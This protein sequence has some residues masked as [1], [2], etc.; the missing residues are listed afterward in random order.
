MGKRQ[1]TTNWLPVMDADKLTAKHGGD[2]EFSVAPDG[3]PTHYRLLQPVSSNGKE[4][5][6]HDPMARYVIVRS[7]DA[8]AV[9]GEYVSNEG[10]TIVLKNA[11]QLWK[12][13]ASKGISLLDVAMFGVIRDKCRFSEAEN[14]DVTIFDACA[15]IETS[16]A[17]VRSI[18]GAPS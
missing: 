13:R 11:I 10:S 14:A 3:S 2:I 4:V 12:W 6:N 7:R 8:G 18:M 17:A 5:S 1:H 16:G 9:F 15:M